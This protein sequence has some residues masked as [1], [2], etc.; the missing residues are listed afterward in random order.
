MNSD[1]D[2]DLQEDDNLDWFEDTSPFYSLPRALGP[3]REKDEDSFEI[4]REQYLADALAKT[5]GTANPSIMDK[6][7]WKYMIGRGNSWEA[8]NTFGNPEVTYGSTDI[9]GPVWCFERFGQTCTVLPDGRHVFIAGEHEDY[10]D[11]D[12]CIY[13][14]VV[15]ISFPPPSK[16]G[17]P[18]SRFTPECI[19]IYGYPL[20]VFPPTD[21]HTSTYFVDQKCGDEYIYIVGG[22]GYTGAASR[23]RTDVYRL[24]LSDFSIH[25][26]ETSGAK[27]AGGTQRHEAQLIDEEGSEPSIKITTTQGEVFSLLIN[28]LE[29]TSHSLG[30]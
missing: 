5:Y 13:N 20:D 8:R 3:N 27:P 15:V 30:S 1:D 17:D 18:P 7:F 2:D 11:P 19:T 10:Y 9:Q 24:D 23:E 22:L 4:T 21:F 12:F 6:P 26:L 29:W 25:H 16:E 14:D 28:S